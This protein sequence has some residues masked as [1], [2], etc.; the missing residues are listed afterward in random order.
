MIRKDISIYVH[1]PFCNSKCYYCSFISSVQ[2]EEKKKEYFKALENEIMN[3]KEKYFLASFEKKEINSVSFRPSK[4]SGE[5]SSIEN[6]VV[7]TIYIGGGTPSSVEPTYIENILKEI[8]KKFKVDK[9]AEITIE[10]N[11]NSTDETKL[12]FYKKIGINRLSFGVQSF[13]KHSLEFVGRIQNDKKML[14]NYIKNSIKVLEKGKKLGFDNISVD[15]ILGLPYQKKS[16]IKKFIKR[17]SKF[18]THFSFYMLMVEDGTK[19]AELLP[20]GVE[21]DKIARLYE[22]AVKML[23]K[24]GFERYEISN[25]AKEGFKSKHNKVYWNM[26]EYIGFGLA[27][28]SFLDGKRIANTEK[29]GDFISYYLKRD[30]KNVKTIESLTKEQLAEETIMLALRTSEGLDL[31][32]FRNNFYDLEKKKASELAS[33]LNLGFLEF[34]NNYLRLSN[35]GFLVA[36]KLILELID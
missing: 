32:K 19:L 14:K 29:L 7:K 31:V 3:F 17:T 16:E 18:V 26:G 2:S 5:I 33:L 15:F 12:A 30:S 27:A 11:P 4:T 21:D 23:K 20:Q 6:F 35:K 8:R 9:N 24:F 1:I 13:N 28:H 10:C 36:N 25:F 34:E 22:I